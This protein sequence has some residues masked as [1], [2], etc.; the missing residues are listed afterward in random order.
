MTVKPST[1]SQY[2]TLLGKDLRREFRTRDMLTSMGLYAVLLI[3]VLGV[4]L[5]QAG[6]G[7]DIVRLSGGL[8]WVLIVFAALLG[9]GRQ[10][11]YEKEQNCIEGLLMVPMDRSVIYLAKM[12][13]S[14]IFLAI[15]ELITLPLFYFL[16]LTAAAP[17]ETFPLTIVP[18]I[19][20]TIGISAVGTLLSTMTFEA[21]GRDVLLAILFIPVIYPLLYACVAATTCMIVGSAECMDVFRTGVAL[22]A[23]Y[24][25]VMAAV[26]WLLYD[27]VISA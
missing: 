5:T 6:H 25:V 17:A 19:L 26:S 11:A 18:I 1:F 22:A 20:G 24:D 4:A 14:I 10:F 16:F 23:G 12:T 13:S 27:Y 3:I 7:T 2:R 9:L 8:V 21:R 15:V